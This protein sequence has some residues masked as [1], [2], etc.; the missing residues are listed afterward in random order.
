MLLLRTAWRRNFAAGVLFPRSLRWSTAAWW[1]ETIRSC[2]G[3]WWYHCSCRRRSLALLLSSSCL[4]WTFILMYEGLCSCIF[5]LDDG[6]IMNL[7]LP[8]SYQFERCPSVLPVLLKRAGI[9]GRKNCAK[10]DFDLKV[11]MSR[12]EFA[13]SLWNCVVL[14]SAWLWLPHVPFHCAGIWKGGIRRVYTRSNRHIRD[15]YFV[16]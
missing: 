6:C 11:D 13:Q 10:V 1:L 2:V 16:F 9:S 5:C 12:S 7:C 15:I 8:G 14:E 3:Y 4:L